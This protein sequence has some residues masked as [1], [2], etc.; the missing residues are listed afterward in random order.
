M[1]FIAVLNDNVRHLGDQAMSTTCP[2]VRLSDCPRT[3]TR[4][5]NSVF[6]RLQVALNPHRMTPFL[7]RPNKSA[8]L[9]EIKVALMPN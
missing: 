8:Q 9:L 1:L 6:A 5:V 7:S 2:F 3:N 4:G